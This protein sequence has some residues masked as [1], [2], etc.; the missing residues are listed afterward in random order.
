M[1]VDAALPE[2][3]PEHLGLQVFIKNCL[4]CHRLDGAGEGTMGPDLARPIPVTEYLTD[5]GLRKLIRDPASV[6]S[7]P[8]MQMKGFDSD[9]ISDE[10][11]TALIA[12][13]AYVASK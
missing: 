9:A 6:R 5:D 10:E 3:A 1:A 12:Y 13:L 8:N 2:N 11:L 4:P 7:W